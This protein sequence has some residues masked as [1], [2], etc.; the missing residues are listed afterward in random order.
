M[1]VIALL[2]DFGT[3]DYYVGAMKGVI[4]SINPD[5]K[6][7]DISHE[8]E[9]QNINAASFTLRAC[10]RNFPPKTIFV[11]I[12]DPGVGSDR[13]AILIETQNYFFIAPDNGTLSFVYNE[14]SNF[15]VFELTNDKFLLPSIS[16]TFHGRDIFAPCA[17][18]LSNGITPEEFGEEIT[19][20]VCNKELKPES[21]S[22]N[23]IEA[24]II[25]ID[26]FGN[27]VTNLKSTDTP[28]K[29]VLNINGNIIKKLYRHYS[30]A[31]GLEAFMI[32]GSAGYLEISAYRDSAAKVLKAVSGQKIKLRRQ[33]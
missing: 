11:A 7:V 10:Y 15:R 8:I 5:A 33:A 25:N 21:I 27:I 12:V 17:A 20:F 26:R 3:A 14:T 4:L 24:S 32:W 16:R 23:E 28:E 30:E 2:T 19:D 29:F 31:N 9:P 18:H 1:N 6:I 13:K 22:E